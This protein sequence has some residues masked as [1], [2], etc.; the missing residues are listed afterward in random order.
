MVELWFGHDSDGYEQV[1]L[2]YE[3]ETV[4]IH[5][6]VAIADGADAH[7]VWSDGEYV[8]HH[9]I[10][11]PWL[12]TPDNIEVVSKG[13][14]NRIHKP[15]E[16]VNESDCQDIRDTINQTTLSNLSE[17]YGVSK[18]AIAKHVYGNC[19]HC[20]EPA[21]EKKKGPR[22]GDWRDKETFREL[23]IEQGKTLTEIASELGCSQA[24]A[25][26]WKRRHDL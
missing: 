26:N 22:N 7:K 16:V 6:L 20:S 4:S 15:R 11:I 9:E 18:S 2:P 10:E 21:V 24:T 14:H 25:S 12:N 3:S 17:E 19:D 13:E 1:S 8:T 23:Y 5:Q